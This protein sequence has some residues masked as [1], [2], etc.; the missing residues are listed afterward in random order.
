QVCS[1]SSPFQRDVED[2]SAGHCPAIE[3]WLGKLE[4]YLEN[5]SVADVR[6]L[7]EE[8]EIAAP[9]ASYQGGLLT[10][11]GPQRQ[12]HWEHFSNRL[13]LCQQLGIKTIVVAIDI[14]APLDQQNLDRACASLAEIAS[15]ASEHNIQVAMEFQANSAFGNNLQTAAMLVA[16]VGSAHLG[17]CFDLFHF[18]C[19]PSKLSDVACLTRDN[20]FHVQLSDL[21]GPVRELAID[22]DRILPGDGEIP[23]EPIVEHCRKIGYDGSISVE[24][25]NPQIWNIP[26][27]QFGEIATTALRMVLGLASN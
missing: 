1:L 3:L 8:N 12:Q 19:G 5:H 9:V 24:L 21:A 18:Y 16:E 26:A 14:L 10:S 11:Q 6:R 13:Q 4:S 17:I 7:L 23:V 20:L 2:Y 22:A 25:M 15:L 27:L